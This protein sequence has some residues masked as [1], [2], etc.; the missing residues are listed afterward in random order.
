VLDLDR[1]RQQFPALR[2]GNVV[3]LDNPA[4]TQITQRAIN[5]INEYLLTCNA[6]HGGVF[7]TSI[8]SDLLLSEAHRAAADFINASKPEEIIFGANMTTLTFAISRSI[9]RTLRPGD[10]IIVTRLD[11][12]ANISPWRCLEQEYGAVIKWA[13]IR[14]EDVTLDMEHL[15]SL[16]GKRTRLVAC[17]WASNAAGS[18]VDVKTVAQLAH[19]VGAW[20]FV[21]AVHYAPHGPIDVQE[22]GCDFLAC[23]VYKFFGPHV[24]ILYGREDLLDQLP[25]FKVRP[26]DSRP[27][28]KFETGT[29]NHEG[30]AGSLGAIEYLQWLGETFGSASPGHPLLS[31]RRPALKRAMNCLREYEREL[32]RQL[33]EGLLTIPRLKIWGISSLDRLECRVPT[34]SITVQGRHPRDLA[35]Q[36]AEAKIYAWNGN[37]YALELME[38]LNLQAA[39]GTVRLGLVHYNTAAEVDRTLEAIRSAV[40][41]F[42]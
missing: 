25:A 29:Q 37:F 16:I 32:G 22:C 4:G 6:N 33:I 36:L 13:D 28:G 7:K 17:C 20:C 39:G 12:D 8:E 42:G 14:E 23:S 21:D 5:R 24:G 30:I 34:V 3:F 1:V 27:P 11:H 18:I 31:G 35:L 2:K 19:S 15:A 40:Q 9:G 41:K 38:R 10:E 26:A